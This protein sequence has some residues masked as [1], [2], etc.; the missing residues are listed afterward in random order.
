[1]RSTSGPSIVGSWTDY[2]GKF[3]SSIRVGN[4]A[5]TQFHPEKSQSA[6]LRLVE[7][8]VKNIGAPALEIAVGG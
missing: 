3:A 7:N 4:V 2:G 6:G 8:F 1:M 5:A